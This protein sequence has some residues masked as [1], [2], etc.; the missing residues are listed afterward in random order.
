[1]KLHRL[2]LPIIITMFVLL[3]TAFFTRSVYL[4]KQ[5]QNYH[6]FINLASA[7]AEVLQ[8]LIEKDIDFIGAGANFFYSTEKPSWSRFDLFAERLIQSSDTLISLQWM[9]KVTFSEL[10]AHIHKTKAR[11]PSFELHT[12]P[13][14]GER[15]SGYLPTDQQPIY[16]ASDIS[17]KTPENL[18]LLGFYSYRERFHLVLES[19][20]ATGLPN[21]S[22]KV[23]LLQDG[24]DRSIKKSGILVYHPVFQPHSNELYGVMAGVIRIT[25]YFDELVLKTSTEKSI[26]VE[27]VDTGFDAEDDP[28]LFQS[29]GWSSLEGIITSK[30]ITLQNRDWVVN[31]KTDDQLTE[32]QATVV[33]TMLLGGVVI[34]MLIGLIVCLVVRD[35]VQLKRLLEE[36]TKELNFFAYHDSLTGLCNR[37]M[38]ENSFSDLLKAG[39]E[40]SLI[41]LDIDKFKTI[42]DTYGHPAGDAVLQHLATIIAPLLSEQDIYARVGGDELCILSFTTELDELSELLECIR[43]QADQIPTEFDSQ[44]ISHTL[45]I[46]AAVWLGEGK[47]VFLKRVDKALYESKQHGR[48]HVTLA[49]QH[50]SNYVV[51]KALVGAVE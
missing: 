29:D 48:N 17:P 10:D 23:R 39:R 35:K 32:G 8:A 49:A 11:F 14:G 26:L 6:S 3:I 4:A 12:V 41:A 9:E 42:N 38:Y 13:K 25:N 43:A 22:D 34:A 28:L 33:K 18:K 16:I 44:T 45:S 19:I 31:F 30:K 50:T 5:E 46:G 37:R 2:V 51:N 7:Q 21:V 1:M 36:R 15:T 20:T 24:V 27:I 47:E 40:F